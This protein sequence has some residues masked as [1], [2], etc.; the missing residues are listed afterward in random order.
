MGTVYQACGFEML[1]SAN[2]LGPFHDRVRPT[3]PNGA[4]S[5][6]TT[7]EVRWTW[8]PLGTISGAR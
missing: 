3:G 8:M 7:A 6:A 2:Y 4:P 5:S 1:V